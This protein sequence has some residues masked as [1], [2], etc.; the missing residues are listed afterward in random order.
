MPREATQ[1]QGRNGVR[2][3]RRWL[4]ATTF[5]EL[6][7]D[8]YNN[9][10]FCTLP[11]LKGSPKAW[12]LSGSFLHEKR[13]RVFV[14]NKAEETPGHQTAQFQE[15]LAN[16]YSSTAKQQ[17]L[18]EK[19]PNYEYFW[20]TTHPFGATSNWS[21]LVTKESVIDAVA[22]KDALPEGYFVDAELAALVASRI[23][24][25]VTSAK[26]ERLTL[27]RIELD[28]V[29]LALERKKDLL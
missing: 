2:F 17:E 6:Q 12:D 19:D 25:L 11:L 28:K 20:V 15:F 9:E 23:W 10:E 27:E 24:L 26:Q 7:W 13:Q 4:E 3:T 14:E 8:S 21:S 22:A 16:A 5:V 29:L 1:E 18:I